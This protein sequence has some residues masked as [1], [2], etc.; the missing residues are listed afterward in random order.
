MKYKELIQF[1]PI[2]TIVKL[3]DSA[4]A[5]KAQK[6]V[7][8]Y[9]I[10]DTM[11]ER[12]T[13]IVFKQIDWTNP[14]EHKGMLIV[15]N[16]GTGKSHL[17]SFI[18]AVASDADMVQ[19]IQNS[20]VKTAAAA[21]T[22]KF[23]VIREEIGA[24]TTRLRQIVVG[25]L[26]KHLNEVGV[27]YTIPTADGEDANNKEWMAEMMKAYK[28]KYPDKGLLF[29]LDEMLDYLRSL[30]EKEL[31]LALGFMRE[32]GEFADQRDENDEPYRFYFIGGVQEAIFDSGRFAF[33]SDSLG[34]VAERFKQVKIDRTDVKY[35]IAERL[36]R[37]TAA[38]LQQV[39]T[40][41]AKFTKCY[42]ELT[43][44][45]DDFK[46]MFP[47][48][49]DFVSIFEKI[50]CVEKRRILDTLSDKMTELL[51]KEVPADEPGLIAFD[52]YWTN[53]KN[54]STS[55]TNS[56][57]KSV[58]DVVNQLD[59]KI[60]HGELKKA[61]VPMAHRLVNALAV[62]R[63]SQDT[64]DSQIGLTA[65]EMRE[66]LF[67]YDA[68][69]AEDENPVN[70]LRDQI[71]VVM[72]KVMLAVDGRFVSKNDTNDQFYIDVHKNTDYEQMIEKKSEGLDDEALD[73][74]YFTALGQILEVNDV[75][76]AVANYKIWEYD[77]VQWFTHKTFRR[78]YLFFGAPNERSTAQPPRDYYIYFLHPFAKTA[79]TDDARSDEVFFRLE[80]AD[81]NLKKA[82]GLYAAAMELAATHTGADKV[83][84]QQKANH[85][86]QMIG[87]WL[88]NKGI[89]AFSV[90]Y[91][92][93]KKAPSSWLTGVNVRELIGLGAEETINLR[94]NV[95]VLVGTLLAGCF[96]EQAPEYP[97]FNKYIAAEARVTAV[98]DSLRMVAGTK[99]KQGAILLD[100][101]KL[102]DGNGEITV[103]ESPYAAKIKAKLAAAGEGKVVNRSDLLEAVSNILYFDP[104]KS[105]L[106]PELLV[107]ALAALVQSGD[108][109]LSI[110]GQDFTATKLDDLA[111]CDIDDLA[112]FKHISKPK[113]GNT[114]ALTA[115]FKLLGLNAVNV[116][117]VQQNKPEPVVDFQ[118]KLGQLVPVAATLLTRL[119][120]GVSFLGQDLLAQCGV[121]N[122]VSTVRGAK[123]LLEKLQYFSTPAKML[124]MTIKKAEIEDRQDAVA[125][126]PKLDALVKFCDG[127]I[128]TVGYIDKAAEHSVEGDAWLDKKKQTYTEIKQA[129]VAVNKL[130]ALQG[131]LKN[132][133]T[134]LLALE[135]EWKTHYTSLHNRARLSA[136]DELKKQ[137]IRNSPLLKK[138]ADLAT[139]EILPK[140]DLKTFCEQLEGMKICRDFTA[141]S[142]DGSSLCPHCLYSPKNDGTGSTAS[143]V[144]SGMSAQLEQ[145]LAKWTETI[146]DN[147]ATPAVQAQFELIS[148]DEKA[149]IDAFV[150]SKDLGCPIPKP[151]LE[152][153]R[154]VLG[155]LEKIVVKGEDFAAKL[156]ALGPVEVGQL[157][158]TINDFFADLVEGK[159]LNKVRVVVE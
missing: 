33:V 118:T 85:H 52:S 133:Q 5:V 36:L 4:V 15:G 3:R 94:D 141:H 121:V 129:I 153:L 42:E 91:K 69:S 50:N 44:R 155:G 112:N 41:L 88:N 9:V 12:L 73:R 37:K 48:H 139:I 152:G 101:L 35:V 103:A 39:E 145:M 53:V 75:P 79:F 13:E 138:L 108:A 23:N 99:T 71:A 76:T 80:G 77:K 21:I 127:Q 93:D 64:I 125:L 60:D 92:G 55:R 111:H 159:D 82:L 87:A 16:Y 19:Y 148:A 26:Q 66:Q 7:S 59:E 68:I 74:A 90:T 30:P 106:E 140:Q 83:H 49:P 24:V 151:L 110:P 72:K 46:R 70:A 158:K 28:A 81:A 97:V 100:G 120:R 131:V 6:L 67:V 40:H 102:V 96:D 150:A 63:L 65:A 119:G 123:E 22:G 61:Y 89:A 146:L 38:Q 11:K 17:M 29:V 10:S 149:A 144:L 58:I 1:D 18:S 34:R 154:K 124:A 84:F 132:A 137:Q 122:S 20:D 95:H 62:H 128:S 32:L 143:A 116:A 114:E 115:A 105:R 78:G 136:A 51:E 113:G 54:D 31:V 134:A 86:L 25:R 104:A 156:K 45:M 109:V 43:P 57:T 14:V 147:L 135:D 27:D 8:S 47:V 142:L 157:Q 2:T 56:D 130:D 98:K 107:L 117:K 126:I